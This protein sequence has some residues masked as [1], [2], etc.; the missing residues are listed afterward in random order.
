MPVVVDR[1]RP[2]VRPDVLARDVKVLHRALALLNASVGA[3]NVELPSMVPN[4]GSKETGSGNYHATVI[5]NA[6]QRAG[7]GVPKKTCIVLVR[8]LR[9]LW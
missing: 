9:P 8:Y 2:F 1:V 7:I 6:F 4:G 5:N 3:D